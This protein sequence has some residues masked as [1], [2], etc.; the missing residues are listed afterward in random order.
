MENSAEREEIM[1]WR[2]AVVFAVRMISSTYRTKKAMAGPRR[3]INNDESHLEAAKPRVAR[4]EVNWVN[5]VRG[6]YLSP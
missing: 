3:R 6:A 4:K 1:E 5:Q 2:R